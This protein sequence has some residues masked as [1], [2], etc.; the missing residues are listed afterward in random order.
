MD[1]LSR[2]CARD[3]KTPAD[4]RE[5]V[6]PL[7]IFQ[8]YKLYST[9]AGTVVAIKAA[10]HGRKT[11]AS[12]L[13]VSPPVLARFWPRRTGRG[14]D[15]DAASMALMAACADRGVIDPRRYG[16]EVAYRWPLV[17]AKVTKTRRSAR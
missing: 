4:W 15:H 7:G 17:G 13:G 14:W 10:S 11:I 5:L 1:G 8:D 9:L 6:L 16:F 2:F 3:Q 12:L